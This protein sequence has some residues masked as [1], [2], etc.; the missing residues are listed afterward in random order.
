VLIHFTILSLDSR[1]ST[2]R[3]VVGKSPESGGAGGAASERIQKGRATT[4]AEILVKQS[5]Y[6]SP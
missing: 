1:R 5:K 6:L 3:V 4:H 2:H